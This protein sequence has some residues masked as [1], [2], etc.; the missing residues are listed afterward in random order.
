MNT[1]HPPPEPAPLISLHRY[2]TATGADGATAI[3]TLRAN[4]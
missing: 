2:A 4:A 1:R 3:S